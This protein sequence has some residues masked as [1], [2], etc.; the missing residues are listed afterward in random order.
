M[1]KLPKFVKLKITVS[2]IMYP[3]TRRSKVWSTT[4]FITWQLMHTV[5]KFVHWLSLRNFWPHDQFSS[6]MQVWSIFKLIE[7]ASL[8]QIEPKKWTKPTDLMPRD[9]KLFEKHIFC[10][11][12][13][14]LAYSTRIHHVM[15]QRNL[16]PPCI[17]SYS[18]EQFSN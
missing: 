9:R 4:S 16:G 17:I 6:N 5:T 2:A 10:S 15:K 8:V 3:L 1:S 14:K 18:S 13:T 11:N 12:W 7:S